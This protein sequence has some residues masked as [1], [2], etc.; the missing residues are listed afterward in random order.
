MEKIKTF[1]FIFIVLGFCF[2]DANHL[3]F[4]RITLKPTNA[5]FVSIYN[6]VDNQEID[7]SN[8]YIN[9]SDYLD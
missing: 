9:I 7:L 1:S 6:S 3:I 4:N 2:S 8:Y 5:E